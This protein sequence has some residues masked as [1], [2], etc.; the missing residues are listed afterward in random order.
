M[1]TVRDHND[2]EYRDDHPDHPAV[3]DPHRI[4]SICLTRKCGEG[5]QFSGPVQ[6]IVVTKTMSRSVK[7]TIHAPRSTRIL[8]DEIVAE[9]PSPNG[10]A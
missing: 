8:R 7:L 3:T 2:D 5:I 9:S 10:A 6:S 4:T 1:N